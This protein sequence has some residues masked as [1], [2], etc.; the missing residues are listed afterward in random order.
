MEN[1]GI[2]RQSVKKSITERERNVLGQ[3]QRECIRISRYNVRKNSDSVATTLFEK[4]GGKTKE[5]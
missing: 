2:V 5:R 3:E 4:R 1:K